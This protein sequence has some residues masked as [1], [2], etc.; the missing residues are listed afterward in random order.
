MRNKK[1]IL[2]VLLTAIVFSLALSLQAQDDSKKFTGNFSFGYRMVGTEGAMSKYKEDFNL[3]DGFR[4]FNLNMHYSPGEKLEKLFDGLDLRIYNFGGDPFESFGLSVQKYGVYKFQYDRKK[5]TYFYED[6][7]QEGGHLYDLHTFDFQRISD[8]GSL[9]VSLT[10]NFGV[11]LN[12]DKY[13]KEGESVTTYDINRIE[14]EFD[15]P[16]KEESKSI[17]VGMDFHANRYSVLAE[18]KFLEY[19]NDNS[20][21]LPGP[22]DGGEGAS[23][24]SSLSF[25]ILNQPYDF[26]TD[27]YTL[28][29]N[30]NPFNNLLFSGSA[31]FNNQEMSLYFSEGARGIDYLGNCFGYGYEG[32]ADFV[33]KFNLYDA[34]MTYMLFNKLAIVGAVRYNEFEQSGDMTISGTTKDTTLSYDTFAV[35]GGLQYQISS[36]FSITGGYRFEERNLEGAE[37]VEYMTD[38][39]RNGFFGNLKA[40]LFN[41][42]KLTLDYQ[43]GTYEN[44]Y[45]L[46]GPTGFVRFRATAK[47][48]AKEFS[49]STSYLMNQTE[50]EVFD[51][52]AWESHKNQF[53]L[54]LG[55]SGDIFSVF[56][57]YALIDVERKGDRTIMYPPAWSGGPG[58][59][60]WDI[61][62]EG[63]SNL[64]DGSVSASLSDN[65][66]VGAY[67]YYYKNT[68]FWEILRTTFKGYI[69]YIFDNGIVAQLGYRAVKFEE[70]LS[71]NND[72]KANILEVSF[73]YRWK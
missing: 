46:I 6:M 65:F 20:L 28:K 44:P 58:T 48:T 40:D 30:A 19:S 17:A 13:T 9:K 69:E 1:I 22:A 10:K 11:Y 63:T 67:Y 4:L 31:Q 24:P 57:G 50:S 72:Y 55:Y 32:S 29:L 71:G 27:T 23:Y 38:T 12:F 68:G 7:Q 35:E 70:K 45:T 53:N 14:F 15:K 37:T 34:D 26:K 33:R 62:Y 21:F 3:E 56:A 25:F 64:L 60:E 18:G 73:G 47:Y 42:F 43:H 39:T 41:G 8:S 52:M 16:I 5:S 36:R 51:A 54:R 66:K 61:L 49:L 2:P 59:F